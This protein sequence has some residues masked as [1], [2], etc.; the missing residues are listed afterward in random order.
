MH[1]L[2]EHQGGESLVGSIAIGLVRTFFWSFASSST[3]IVSP[4]ATATTRPVCL[5]FSFLSMAAANASARGQRSAI[6]DSP[7]R[8][9][10]DFNLV[11]DCLTAEGPR[12]RTFAISDL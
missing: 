6:L 12:D 4:S 7:L 5:A 1:V 10:T 3:V 2:A 9:F 11:V 8:D